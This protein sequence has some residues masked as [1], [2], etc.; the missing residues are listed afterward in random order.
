L[1]T[2][3]E[4]RNPLVDDDLIYHYTTGA[5]C[6]EHILADRRLRFTSLSRTND[7]LE[8]Q[9]FY[10]SATGTGTTRD[11]LKQLLDKGFRINDILK[12]FCKICCFSIDQEPG[13]V[14]N[15]TG[16]FHKEFAK[17]RMWSQ[18]A[19]YHRG[20]CLVFSASRLYEILMPDTESLRVSQESIVDIFKG[21]V[22]Y[23]NF[24]RKLDETLTIEY[25]ANELKKSEIDRIRENAQAYL[26]TKLEDYKDEQEYRIVLY[27]SK[28]FLDGESAYVRF[29]D[30][31][32]CVILGC[33]FPNVYE[34]NIITF[35]KKKIEFGVVKLN[36]IHG[37]PNLQDISS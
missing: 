14:P 20:V 7:P 2:A 21:K 17:S 12:Q 25:S 3:A 35:S 11:Q 34:Q 24:L 23:N 27:S 10:H 22:E 33:S 31:L 13:T 19:N 9:D 5:D 6:I 8:Y 1:I 4:L 26:F 28:G 15:A 36:W 16:L 18:Y 29:G 30:A 32:Q 37:M